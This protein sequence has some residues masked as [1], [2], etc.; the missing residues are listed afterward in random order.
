MA[1]LDPELRYLLDQFSAAPTAVAA[2]NAT[3]PIRVMLTYAND[4]QPLIDLGFTVDSYHEERVAGYITLPGLAALANHPNTIQLAKSGTYYPT[5]NDSIPNI[6]A[7]EVWQVNA[8]NG[9]FTGNTGRGVIVGIVDTGID[10]RHKAFRNGTDSRILRIWDQS[11]PFATETSSGKQAPTVPTTITSPKGVEYVQ[12]KITDAIAAANPLSI[13]GQMDIDGHGTHVAGTAAGNGSQSGG[14]HGGFHYVGVAPQ[15]DLIVV[16]LDHFGRQPDGKSLGAGDADILNGVRYVIFHAILLGKRAVINLSLGG[17]VGSHDGMGTLEQD[18]NILQ[19]VNTDVACIVIS[20]GNEGNDNFHAQTDVP[21][22]GAVELTMT[23]QT[24]VEEPHDE[25]IEIWYDPA[26]SLTCAVQPDGGAFTAAVNKTSAQTFVG[27]NNGGDVRID[28]DAGFGN[29]LDESFAIRLIPPANGKSKAGT[30][31]IRLTNPGAAPVPIHAW[32]TSFGKTGS[33]LTNFVNNRCTLSEPGSAEEVIT[34][35]SHRLGT[36][37]GINDG[38]ISDFSSRG[39]TRTGLF[40]KPDLTAPGEN[41][42]APGITKDR[43][44]VTDYLCFKCCCDC[45]ADFYVDM[46]GTSMAAPHVTGAVALMLKKDRTLNHRAVKALL[47]ANV[48]IDAQTGSII[49][50]PDWGFGK[51]NVAKAV[52]A[53]TE[54]PSAA[55]ATPAPIPAPTPMTAL[56]HRQ[57]IDLQERFLRTT[58][59]AE[60][61][62]LIRTYAQEINQLINSNKRVATVWHRSGGPAWVR[63]AFQM[64]AT[65]TMPLPDVANGYNLQAGIDRMLTI[66][67]RYGSAPLVQLL[68][69]YESDLALVQPGRSL[70]QL[71]DSLDEPV[72]AV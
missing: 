38:N 8:G 23:V 48:L 24:F 68:G 71:L 17:Q 58:R 55:P 45:C 5:L 27:I 13:V 33:S 9:T 56:P 18:L 59:G 26:L 10:Y 54:T 67:K 49:P 7:N 52:D 28:G 61:R 36:F 44:E 12:E 69:Q 43:T 62:G 14:C 11:V 34:V 40:N 35:G 47:I 53:V 16:K 4:L 72:H 2:P 1:R 15:A 31:R 41:I 19:R 37:L 64:A 51:I 70:L 57:L 39:P 32:L 6:R 25:T 60:W 29:S 66:L 21:A 65:P 63:V 50:N 30:W 22:N 42:T 3:T 20:A 46:Q